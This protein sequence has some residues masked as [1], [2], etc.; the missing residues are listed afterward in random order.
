ML[1]SKEAVVTIN[2]VVGEPIVY[3][4]EATEEKRRN[5]AARIEKA[6]NSNYFGVRYQD[7]LVLVP[8]HNIRSVEISPP[9]EGIITNV[10]N[11]VQIVD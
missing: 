8:M 1:K 10:A 5:A 6:M 11:D 7:R 4:I 3:K 9:P 2:L